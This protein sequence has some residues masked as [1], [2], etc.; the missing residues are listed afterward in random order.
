MLL[1]LRSPLAELAARIVESRLPR[2][3]SAAER[4]RAQALAGHIA[5]R[6][7]A[8]FSPQDVAAHLPQLQRIVLGLPLGCGLQ[9]L[10]AIET[11]NPG[12]S[13]QMPQLGPVLHLLDSLAGLAEV[14]RL[15]RL[16]VLAEALQ[17]RRS[18]GPDDV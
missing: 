4:V 5:D 14:F 15:D 2:R 9:V 17:A 11:A 12:A 10:E 7:R 3:W 1:I 16:N 18:A 6:V 8:R 13:R